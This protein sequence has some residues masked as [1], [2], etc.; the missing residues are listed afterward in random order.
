MDIFAEGI[1][2]KLI[3]FEDGEKYIVSIHQDKRRNYTNPEEIVQAEAF[4]S[5]VLTY[6]YP[7]KRIRQ[8]VPVQMGSETKEAGVEGGARGLVPRRHQLRD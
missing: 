5:L 8:F 6:K 1:K 2:Q 3:R 7:V 4:L